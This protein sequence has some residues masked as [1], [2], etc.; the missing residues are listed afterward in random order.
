MEIPPPSLSHY[1]Y[2]I[3]GYRYGKSLIPISEDDE[4]A[5]KF[6]APRCLSLMGFTKRENVRQH[7][8]I[9]TSVQVLTANPD[10]QV[11]EVKTLRSVMFLF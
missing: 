1:S 3:L 4:I 7:Q 2:N 9:G 6:P 5:M 10:D 11:F 8:F